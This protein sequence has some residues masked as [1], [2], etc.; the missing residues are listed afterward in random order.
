[1]KVREERKKASELQKESQ[2]YPVA[3]FPRMGRSETQALK[4]GLYRNDFISN[5]HCTC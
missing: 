5:P 3:R 4:S 2:E 1:M